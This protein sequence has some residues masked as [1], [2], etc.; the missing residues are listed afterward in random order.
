MQTSTR[1]FPLLVEPADLMEIVPLV[2][3]SPVHPL[4]VWMLE[5]SVL[6]T[7]IVSTI[8]V[9]VLLQLLVLPVKIFHLL[10]SMVDSSV[11]ETEIA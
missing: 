8:S 5:N 9:I 11:V 2:R 3:C 1:P 4:H 6:E 7:E 10:V